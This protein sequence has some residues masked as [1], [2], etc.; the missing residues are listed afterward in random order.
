MSNVPLVFILDFILCGH[1]LLHPS[2][3]LRESKFSSLVSQDEMLSAA[4]T[5][6][7]DVFMLYANAANGLCKL[8]F[9]SALLSLKNK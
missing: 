7:N 5:E 4:E 6:H 9:R 8:S 2:T 1:K 3:S